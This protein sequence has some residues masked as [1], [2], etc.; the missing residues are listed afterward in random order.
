MG[1]WDVR[2]CVTGPDGGSMPHPGELAK[3]WNK[4]PGVWVCA[5][6]V[7][8]CVQGKG[9]PYLAGAGQ[10]MEQAA[11]CVCVRVCLC[12]CVCV[13][14]VCVCEC[15]NHEQVGCMKDWR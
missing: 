6:L 15:V 4:Q 2:E 8:V 11:R 13:P 10:A 14:R 12:L 5:P 9:Q 3:P 1:W 7:C